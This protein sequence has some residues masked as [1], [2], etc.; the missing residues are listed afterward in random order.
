MEG[1]VLGFKA[2]YLVCLPFSIVLRADM[3]LNQCPVNPVWGTLGALGTVSHTYY[4]VSSV[5]GKH[6]HPI[7]G[8]W[9]PR[10]Y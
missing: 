5:Q 6:L 3:G 10:R 4:W 2:I 8:S 7:T 9:A 1:A